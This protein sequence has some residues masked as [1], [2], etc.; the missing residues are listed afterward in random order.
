LLTAASTGAGKANPGRLAA[1]EL[2]WSFYRE[3]A[4]VFAYEM[5]AFAL[6]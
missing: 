1:V 6:M 4:Y 2:M 5:A 3:Q